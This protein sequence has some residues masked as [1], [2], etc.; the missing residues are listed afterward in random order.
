[1]H[2]G[3][4]VAEHTLHA[5]PCGSI[6][7]SLFQLLDLVA[8]ARGFLV[9]LFGYENLELLAELSEFGLGGLGP[10]GAPR[11]L[12]RVANLPVN[13]LHERQQIALEGIVV[14]RAAEAA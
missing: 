9:V 12:A 4:A 10:G 2:R 6:R 13:A 5:A 14:V 8:N 3:R 11:R 1:M 7:S